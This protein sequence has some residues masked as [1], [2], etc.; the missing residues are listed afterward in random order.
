MVAIQVTGLSKAYRYYPTEWARLKEWLLPGQHPRH[1]LA[2]VLQDINFEVPRGE[3]VGILGVNGAGKS[4]LLKIITGT[5]QPTAGE[6]HAEGRI[7]AL[8][9]LGMGFHP[10]FTGRQNVVM[11]G[12]L[13]GLMPDQ[14]EQQ[15]ADIE[16][17]AGIGEYIDYPVRVY[18]SGMQVRLAFAVATAVRPEILIVDEA[19]SVG[20]AAFQRKCYRRINDYIEQGT[21]LLFCTHDIDAVRR[22]CT[23]ALLLREGHVAASGPARGVCDA[24]ERYLF[25]S[26]DQHQASGTPA[27]SAPSESEA[28][29]SA[30]LDP[31]LTPDCETSYGDGRASIR[32]LTMEDSTNQPANVFASGE[33]LVLRV[34]IEWHE[35]V[36][37]VVFAF[38]IKTREGLGLYGLDTAGDDAF[39]SRTFEAGTRVLVRYHIGNAFAPGVYYVNAGIRDDDSE[40][41]TFLHRRV[42]AHMFRVRE[43]A[44]TTVKSGLI[45]VPARVTIEEPPS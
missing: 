6:V 24:Y 29:A 41:Q 20:D 1:T 14:V 7:A 32:S 38:M 2:W 12:Q 27:E 37:G 30:R 5:T 3:A 19:L 33:S 35:R 17:F 9:E 22:L 16:A 39:S 25:G 23:T 26:G 42:D 10:D 28:E 11:A 40:T 21:T 18:S 4:T 15:M 31:E 13:Q 45:N 8:L 43:D 36:S 44:N 34:E